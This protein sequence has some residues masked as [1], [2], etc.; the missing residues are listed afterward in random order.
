MD[1]AITL[2]IQASR[3]PCGLHLAVALAA[4][5]GMAKVLDFGVVRGIIWTY[6]VMMGPLFAIAFLTFVFVAVRLILPPRPEADQAGLVLRVGL[7]TYRWAW[8]QIEGFR[9]VRT[10][11]NF[12]AFN[13]LPLP[14]AAVKGRWLNYAFPG[15]ANDLLVELNR[16][17][18]AARGAGI[19]APGSPMASPEA[20]EA[21]KATI[22]RIN[23]QSLFALMV[24]LGTF[25]L[26]VVGIKL[27]NTELITPIGSGL[28][29]GMIIG[30]AAIGAL[31]PVSILRIANAR[32]SSLM[33]M[34]IARQCAHRG[35]TRR[36]GRVVCLVRNLG[37]DVV[38]P[39]L[40]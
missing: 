6:F 14:D 30:G 5:V 36:R 26:W 13:W 25:V 2:P 19:V 35:R 34:S 9:I 40:Q 15:K 1:S 20:I 39:L 38:R 4:T 23:K 32:R 24:V 22:A 11:D 10:R 12:V 29:W 18:D 27:S 28:E 16:R 7:R 37:V 31:L 17:L 8:G 33:P 21:E 3:F